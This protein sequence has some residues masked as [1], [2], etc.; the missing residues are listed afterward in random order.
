MFSSLKIKTFFF[1]T[2]L[3][4]TTAGVIIIFT[5]RDVGDAMLKAE[6]SSATNILELVELNIKAGYEKLLSDKLDMIADMK[7]RLNDAAQ[8]CLATLN[9][10]ADLSEKKAISEKEAKSRFLNW[11]K[12]IRFQKG[13]MF[14]FNKEAIVISHPSFEL[15]GASINSLKDIKGRQIS[16]V[17]GAENLKLSGETA[18][19]FW[20]DP[21]TRIREK[22]LGFF[23]PFRKWDWTVCAV[24]DFEEIDAESEKKMRDILKVL[25]NTFKRIHIGDDGYVFLF[26]GHGDILIDSPTENL[27]NS[28]TKKNLKTGNI[29]LQDLIKASMEKTIPIRYVEDMTKGDKEIEAHLSYFK[30]FDWYIGVSVPVYEIQK[31]AK[32]LITHQSMVITF[33]FLCSLIAAFF[34]VSEISRPLRTLTSCVKDISR[35]DFVDVNED[36]FPA[37]VIPI[38]SKDEVGRLAETFFL[39][40]TE[41]KKNIQKLIETRASVS[42]ARFKKEAAEAANQAKNKF[43]ANMSHEIRTPMNA[44]VNFCDLLTRTVLSKKQKEYLGIIRSSSWSLLEIINDLLDVS[45][46]EA[47]KLDFEKSPILIREVVEE[48]SNIFRHLIKE[49]K[50]KYNVEF[51][52]DVPLRVITD[53]LRLKQVLINLVS[54]AFKF[55]EKGQITV[56][57]N[58][59]S[60]TQNTAELLFRVED[61]GIGISPTIQDQLFDAFIQAD[62]SITRKYGGTGL[63]LTISKKIIEMMGGNIWVE[64]TPKAGS[65][66]FFSVKFKIASN[67]DSPKRLVPPQFRNRKVLMDN[68]MPGEFDDVRILLVEDNPVNQLVATEVL[69]ISDIT[70]DTAINGIEAVKAVMRNTYDVVLMDIQMPQM[71]GLQA[72]KVIRKKLNMH[73]LPI[74]AMTAHSMKGDRDKC[75]DAGMNGYIAKPID[76]KELFAELRQNIPDEKLL[77]SRQTNRPASRCEFETTSFGLDVEDGLNRIGSYE[78]YKRI[79]QEFIRDNKNLHQEFHNLVINKK[80][81]AA[82]LKAHALKGAAGNVSAKNIQL[83]AEKLEVCCTRRNPKHI[84]EE[85]KGLESGFAQLA[86]AIKRIKTSPNSSLARNCEKT[87]V[88]LKKACQLAKNLDNRL[89]EC[90]PLGSERYFKNIN[91]YLF[92]DAF[93]K[94]R[95][96]MD[97]QISNY[98][99]DDARA[100]LRIV[101]GKLKRLYA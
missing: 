94:D 34:L 90:D 68:M 47:G 73:D 30:A 84:L 54:N 98:Q 58:C 13:F 37:S 67:A 53:P 89:V 50:I 75:F 32:S 87:K 35:T 39:M 6:R 22:K 19:F 69:N 51:A 52:P 83:A 21:V 80:F 29:L 65:S 57:V 24:F 31:P 11:M 8:F 64:S 78:T 20:N 99:F 72:T 62:S 23:I 88:D 43:L 91:Q 41:L 7:W 14:V 100:T 101:L 70:V 1:L 97:Q 85:L 27:N 12:T 66:F 42:K 74:I 93:K 33:I 63:G 9:E 26:D 86:N 55:T 49:K 16:K 4:T 28:F 71:D 95:K 17:M 92:A 5:H 76:C 79:L 2:L 25:K 15:L 81:K 3:M 60:I 82:Q 18:V 36:E 40:R 56:S 44:I 10:Y 38:K 61:T 45:K 59:G 48:V 96:I 77:R 46:I